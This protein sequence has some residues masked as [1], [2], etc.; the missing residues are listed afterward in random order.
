MIVDL[1]AYFSIHHYLVCSSSTIVGLERQSNSNFVKLNW[2]TCQVAKND[3][4]V[5]GSESKNNG[6]VRRGHTSK[7][8][9]Y[10]T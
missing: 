3:K 4:N 8:Q 5:K 9:R 7:S 2:A 6:H 10:E 1:T